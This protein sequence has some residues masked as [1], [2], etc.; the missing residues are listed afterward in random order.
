MKRTYSIT[1]FGCQ[2]NAH[3]SERIAGMLESEGMSAADD[4]ALADVIVFNTCCI[5][6]NADNRLYGN[7]GALKSLKAERPDTRIVVGGCL[8]QK[9]GEKILE[10]AP[11]V[12]VVFG[13]HNV[14]RAPELL[15]LRELSGTS[16][17][18]IAEKTGPEDEFTS[19]LPA[20]RDLP[21]SA[22]VT[23]SI[24]CDNSCTFCIVPAVRGPE[25]SRRPGEIAS[26]IEELAADGVVEVTLL[27]QNV[28]SYG[29][30][31]GLDG[32]RPLF[33]DLLR[34]L[35]EI[36][37]VERI[38][39]TS[40]HP[41]DLRAETIAAMAECDA[42]MPQLHLPLQ[43]GS[44]S[45]LRAMHRGYTAERYMKKLSDARSAIDDLA[46]STD[47][48]VG[49]PGESDADFAETLAVVKEARFDSAFTFVYSPR[50]G[51]AAA[52]MEQFVPEDVASER[53]SVLSALVSRLSLEANERRVGRV[54]RLL[55]EGRSKK[56]PTTMSGR[57]PQGRLVH[58]D[59]VASAYPGSLVDSRITRAAPHHLFGKV[60][61]SA[62]LRRVP[63]RIA[64]GARP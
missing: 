23:I 3:D 40:P 43:S 10:K 60:D 38:R 18:E 51:T 31:L 62:E 47:I 45:I 24:G 58:F 19:D 63:V 57:T 20:R 55:V 32:H 1:T 42:V 27:G 11:H 56:D 13:T 28:N 34:R 61:G 22:W 49:F 4:P 52:E 25:V 48:I 9:D 50:P 36:E 35:D 5:R 37:G 8:A 21:F 17:C 33:A 12:D 54:E 16:V 15:E 30:D 6:E 46:V 29:R 7:L 39:F 64:A 26:E 14:G 2:M 53:C 41:K 59:P 44:N